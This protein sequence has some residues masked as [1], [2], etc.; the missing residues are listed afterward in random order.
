MIKNVKS[1]V[2]NGK[3]VITPDLLKREVPA[4]VFS[5]T[6]DWEKQSNTDARFG[7]TGMTSQYSPGRIF[8]DSDSY[9]D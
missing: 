5:G 8:N 9:T 1:F 4:A 2:K 7:T 3:N 6:Y